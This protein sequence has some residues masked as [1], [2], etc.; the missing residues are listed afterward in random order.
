MLS[1]EGL[2]IGLRSE[3]TQQFDETQSKPNLTI[4]GI[5]DDSDLNFSYPSD[6][7]P[8]VLTHDKVLFE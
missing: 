2:S 4:N 1:L 3:T 6:L 5:L 7:R 8:N